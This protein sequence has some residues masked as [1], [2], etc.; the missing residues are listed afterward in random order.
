MENNNKPTLEQILGRQTLELLRQ[1]GIRNLQVEPDGS[2]SGEQMSVNG[3]PQI[4]HIS[5][6]EIR[7]E[8][9]RIIIGGTISRSNT[10]V[11]KII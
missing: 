8:G 4:N 10:D 9:T 6:L 7:I 3:L 2:I 1:A 5:G 11:G